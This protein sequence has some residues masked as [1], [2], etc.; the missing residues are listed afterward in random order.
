MTV[1][2]DEHRRC[3]EAV[4]LAAL[5]GD[6]G[7]WIAIALAD[8]TSDRVTYDSR[9]A[10]VA[11]QHHPEWCCYLRIPPGGMTAAE[12]VA[13]LGYWRQLAAAA[14]FADPDFPMPLQPLTCAD[15]R[16]QIQVL[17]KGRP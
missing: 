13:V 17:A 10:A 2:G 5:A 8:G 4:T 1:P 14:R 3:A 15:A 9:Q 16:R 7:R 12:A 6:A 11:H